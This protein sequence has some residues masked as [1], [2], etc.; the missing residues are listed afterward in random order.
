MANQEIWY[1]SHDGQDRQGP[2]TWGRIQEYFKGGILSPDTLIWAPHLTE[3]TPAKQLIQTK[4][5]MARPLKVLLIA[6]A[7]FVGLLILSGIVQTAARPSEKMENGKYIEFDEFSKNWNARL[8][9][10]MSN[11]EKSNELTIEQKVTIG[12]TYE[13]LKLNSQDSQNQNKINGFTPV[14][15]K[16]IDFNRGLWTGVKVENG[17][18]NEIL[19]TIN[20]NDYYKSEFYFTHVCIAWQILFKDPHA[21]G[22]LIVREHLNN[23]SPKVSTFENVKIWH[24]RD[25]GVQKVFM[26]FN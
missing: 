17:R 23:E 9:E 15:G 26:K 18:L 3:W 14:C 8:D 6:A 5:G 10:I 12:S 11:A 24:E 13:F 1:Y 19:F 25:N 20:V 2:V 7:S 4:K 16:N 21:A 22:L